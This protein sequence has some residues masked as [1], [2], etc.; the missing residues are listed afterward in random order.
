MHPERIGPYEIEKKIGAGG[1]GNVYL[2]RHETTGQLAAVKVLPASLAREEGFV[3]RFNREIEALRKLQHPNI[4][5][6]YE[7]GVDGETYYY[8]MEYVDGETLTQRIRREKKIPWRDAVEIAIQICAALKAAHDAGVIHRD[9]KPSNLLLTADNK[10]KLTD[11]GVAQVFATARLTVTGGV[12]G[13]AEYM[14]PEQ[15]QGQRAT[16]RS[17]L[18]SLGAVLYVMLTGRPPFTGSTTVEIMHKQRFARFDR[19]KLYV[20][21]IP[22]WL[23]DLVSQLLEKEP[24]KRLPDAYV[25]S[26]RLQEILAK[27]ELSTRDDQA[28]VVEGHITIDDTT[29][30]AQLADPAVG[31]TMMRDLLRGEIERQQKPGVVAALFNN[32]WILLGL[33]LLVIAVVFWWPQR[34]SLT[35]EQQFQAGVDLLQQPAG[36]R[37]LEARERY[38]LPLVQS[39][40]E[41]WSDQVQPYLDRIDA[42]E[43]ETEHTPPRRR[44]KSRQVRSE[45][46]RMLVL[47]RADWE[48]GDYAAAQVKLDALTALLA[49]DPDAG[50]MQSV[51]ESWQAALAE[52]QETLPDRRAFLEGVLSRAESLAVSERAVAREMARGIVVLYENDPSVSDLTARARKLA[53]AMEES[54]R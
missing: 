50:P 25:L 18:Y 5:S 53:A 12:I 54:A 52:L 44:G 1:M 28:T 21:E 51:V 20:P 40:P 33:L 31:A 13:T 42:Y 49:N 14:S 45:P 9:L 22:V 48:R 17:D 38:F 35:P 2:G 37:W 32:I 36:E 16:K 39:D 8:A 47:I 23:D 46:E 15:S 27:V 43:L 29:P 34:K 24:D 11:F 30:N 3:L 4:V 10:V 7:S 41:R 6:L 26:R 19:P